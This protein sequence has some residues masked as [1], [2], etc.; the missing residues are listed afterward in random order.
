[1]ERLR[2]AGALARLDAAGHASTVL[3]LALSNLQADGVEENAKLACKVL[4]SAG[5]PAIAPLFQAMGSDDEQVV[6][7][8]AIVLNRVCGPR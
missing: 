5:E 4:T 1:M 3:P 7:G 8:A 2:S 6:A